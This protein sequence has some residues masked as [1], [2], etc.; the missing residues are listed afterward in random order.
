LGN[1]KP[2]DFVELSISDTGK[3]LKPEVRRGLFNEPFLSTKPRRRGLGLA[4]VFGILSAHD[5]G[6]RLES[7]SGGT[8]VRL[9]IPVARVSAPRRPIPERARGEKILVVDDD[10]VVLK[11]VSAT[12]QGAGYLVETADGPCEA[13]RSFSSASPEPFQL[14]LV[15]V[16]MPEMN[17]FDLAKELLRRHGCVNI[18]FMSGQA[19][20]DTAHALGFPSPFDWLCKPFRPDALLQ[21]VR[22]VFDRDAKGT[23][24]VMAEPTKS[25]LSYLPVRSTVP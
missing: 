18:L 22:S 23:G 24:T 21:A 25:S 13:I 7:D 10:T 5:G 2:G 20:P 9:V 15:D 19:S 4:I 3:G 16:F 14:V 11:M 1:A 17:G 8:K 12:L 6:F